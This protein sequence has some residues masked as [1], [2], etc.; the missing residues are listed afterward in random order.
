MPNST[1]LRDAADPR[2]SDVESCKRQSVDLRETA[3]HVQTIKRFVPQVLLVFAHHG[4]VGCSI[5][6]A[7]ICRNAH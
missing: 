4:H 3:V 6:V 2:H 7:S 5:P 1:T